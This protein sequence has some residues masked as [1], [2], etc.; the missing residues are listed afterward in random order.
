[1]NG[2]ERRDGPV[3]GID[4]DN[5]IAA[6]DAVFHTAAVQRGLITNSTAVAKTSI[7][8]AIRQRSAGE[9]DWQR[10]QAEV[11][12]PRMPQ[13]HLLDGVLPFLHSCRSRSWPVYVVSHKTQFARRDESGTD[14]RQAALVWMQSQKLFDV[15]STGL[16]PERVFFEDTRPAK[17]DRIR[18][19]AC[20]HFIDDLEEVFLEE[21][22]PRGVT[23]ILLTQQ[24]ETTSSEVR[25][26]LDWAAVARVVFDA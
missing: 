21:G 9:L 15:E 13:A 25:P 24:T 12:G 11:Y 2:S 10:L 7:R 3:I 18:Q 16:G 20:T 14:L 8:D 19:L 22:F 23:G 26:A 17:V 6:Y 1:M 4:F 5:T